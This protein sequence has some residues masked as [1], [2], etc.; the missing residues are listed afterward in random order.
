VRGKKN[1]ARQRSAGAGMSMMVS[2]TGCG[3]MHRSTERGA[4]K[5]GS[6]S[7]SAAIPTQTPKASKAGE[8]SF[9]VSRSA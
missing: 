9:Y 3:K 4:V 6:L 8:K 1:L 2:F 5:G 7:S